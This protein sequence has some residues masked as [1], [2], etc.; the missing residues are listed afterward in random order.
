MAT[1]LPQFNDE[2]DPVGVAAHINTAYE[3]EVQPQVIELRTALR[4]IGV[5]TTV[6]AASTSVPIPTMVQLLHLA[7]PLAFGATLALGLI[8]VVRGQATSGARSL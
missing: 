7:N 3:R 4:D 1:E 8:P 5:D 6:R 2:A